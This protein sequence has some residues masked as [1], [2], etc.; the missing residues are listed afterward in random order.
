MKVLRYV[1]VRNSQIVSMCE[2][3]IVVRSR[4]IFV[5]LQPNKSW[6]P[7]LQFFFFIFDPPLRFDY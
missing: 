2:I 4:K 7:T 1:I 6:R 5:P 3:E